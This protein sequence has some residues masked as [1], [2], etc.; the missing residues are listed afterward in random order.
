[1]AGVGLAWLIPKGGGVPEPEPTPTASDRP[2]VTAVEVPLGL[3]PQGV[4]FRREGTVRIFLVRSGES[5]VAFLGESTAEG[6]GPLWWCPRNGLFED[7]DGGVAY[8][9]DGVARAGSERNLDRIRVLVSAGRVTIFPAGVTPGAG[10][11]A[12]STPRNA[13]LPQPCSAAERVG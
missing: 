5:V 8:T 2:G 11:P 6:N 10:A 13:P 4:S 3:I 12:P 1:M 9:K 7:D